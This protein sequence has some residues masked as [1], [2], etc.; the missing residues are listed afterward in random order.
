MRNN[1]LHAEQLNILQEFIGYY[2]AQIAVVYAFVWKAA[3]AK[4][5]L[6]NGNKPTSRWKE[7]SIF[8]LRSEARKGVHRAEWHAVWEEE[9]E[10]KEKSEWEREKR[11]WE[12]ERKRERANTIHLNRKNFVTWSAATAAIIPY[13]IGR[14]LASPLGIFELFICSNTKVSAY[15]RVCVCVC[16]AVRSSQA[17]FA[18]Q[19]NERREPHTTHS[20]ARRKTK[21]RQ[22]WRQEKRSVC[23]YGKQIIMW[24]DLFQ[25]VNIVAFS[26]PIFDSRTISCCCCCF[27]LL[28]FL[29]WSVLFVCRFDLP[30]KYYHFDCSFVWCFHIGSFVRLTNYSIHIVWSIFIAHSGSCPIEIY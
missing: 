22:K 8:R 29:Q 15:A 27:E 5:H 6:L 12:R 21:T 14:V 2:R 26:L 4:L 3:K 16:L 1:K 30:A 7:A 19:A 28:Q 24:L 25:R 11:E 9:K 18:V 20:T 13:N 17:I 10:I 23:G